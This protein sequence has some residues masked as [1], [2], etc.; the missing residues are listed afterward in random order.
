MPINK[1]II[2]VT[3]PAIAIF[4]PSRFLA[5]LMSPI[6]IP[7]RPRIIGYE[8]AQKSIMDIIPNTNEITARPLFFLLI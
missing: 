7:A 4:N 8:K 3:I 2:D 5:I 6:I 1:P